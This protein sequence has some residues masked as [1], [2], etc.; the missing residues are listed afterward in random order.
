M[1]EILGSQSRL[2]QLFQQFLDGQSGDSAFAA[3]RER[4]IQLEL[5]VKVIGEDHPMPL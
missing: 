2:L 4:G 5:E 1:A 3:Q